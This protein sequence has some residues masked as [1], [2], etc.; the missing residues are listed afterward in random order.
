MA[1]VKR[2]MRPKLNNAGS[3]AE[4]TDKLS[5]W[6]QVVREHERIS[7]KGLDQTVKTATL[8]EEAAPQMQEHLRLRSKEICTDYKRVIQAI[9]GYV[10]SKKIWDT[11][12]VD[13]T[14]T[15]S[16]RAKVSPKERTTAK[17]KV[18]VR[19]DHEEILLDGIRKVRRNTS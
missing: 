15:L 7:G 9:E 14:M 10:R 2:I 3:D 18:R 19:P 16:A 17:A 6:Q 8:M 1:L 11:G 12:R 13:M 4:Y 5:E